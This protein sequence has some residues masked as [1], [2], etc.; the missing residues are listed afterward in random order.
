MDAGDPLRPVAARVLPEEH[1]L[2]GL[3]EVVELVGRPAGE[4]AR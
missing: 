3:D 2:A 1:G 4:L